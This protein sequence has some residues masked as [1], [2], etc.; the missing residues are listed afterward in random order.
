M[1][2]GVL[3]T[4][5][6]T[7]I[8]QSLF[9]VGV[10]LFGTP[11]LLVLDYSF[12][13]VLTILLPISFTINVI[14]VWK[15]YRYMDAVFYK[16]ILVFTIPF[17]V[18]FLMLAT[19]LTV[20]LNWIVGLFVMLVACKNA[21]RKMERLIVSLVRYERTYLTAMGMIH[22][23]TNLGGSLLTAI[24]HAKDYDKDRARVT[25]AVTYG[26]FAL[27]QMATLA[28]SEAQLAVSLATDALY[29]ITGALVFFTTER[30]LYYRIDN[31]KYRLVFAAFLFLSGALLLGKAF[32]S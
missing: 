26:T 31:E 9:G 28:L 8:I 25:T 19:R 29:M 18:V 16:R 11:A 3:I 30:V 24:V 1:S 10:L 5:V 7:S 21:S 20:R 14:Q 2:V 6:I 15:H 12:V 32:L 13:Q 17:V 27:F 4:V 22:G 23:L